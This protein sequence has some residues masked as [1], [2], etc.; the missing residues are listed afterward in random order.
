MKT[1]KLI[2]E[3]D[4]ECEQSSLS[5]ILLYSSNP[6]KFPYFFGDFQLCF[7]CLVLLFI[8][9]FQYIYHLLRELNR[10]GNDVSLAGRRFL[11]L[12]CQ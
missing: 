1:L 9:L 3:L 4:A 10:T 12:P 5:I 7:I 11:R 6:P 8:F 2:I